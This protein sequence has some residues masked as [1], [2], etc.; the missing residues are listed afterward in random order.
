MTKAKSTAARRSGALAYGAV[1]VAVLLTL[2]GCG[3]RKSAADYIKAAQA[4]LASNEVHAAI[5]DLKNALQKEPKNVEARTMLGQ[6]YVDLSDATAGEVELQHARDD[7][8]TPAMVNKPLAQAELLL[9]KPKAVLELTDPVQGASPQLAASLLALRGEA[10]FALGQ[11]DEAAKVFAEG[12][13]ADP[14]SVDVQIGMGR[15]ALSQRDLPQAKE[16]LAVAQKEAPKS[17]Q[18]MELAGDVAF[19][20]ADFP[21]SEKAYQSLHELQPWNL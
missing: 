17:P 3:D 12:L 5:I 6:T 1:V 21:G 18:V 7:G 20:G 11:R 2:A 14:N 13:K 4:H 8:A 16:H 10:L 15:A 9:R 19:A